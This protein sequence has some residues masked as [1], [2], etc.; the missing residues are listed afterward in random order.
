M[1]I[2]VA[3]LFLLLFLH[4]AAQVRGLVV[5]DSDGMEIAG[6]AVKAFGRDSLPLESR[7]TGADGR[8]ALSIS[9]DSVRLVEISFTGYEAAKAPGGTVDLGVV[10]LKPSKVVLDAVTVT[11][12]SRRQEAG[13]E[14]ILLTDSIRNSAGTAALMMDALP[15]FKVDWIS[16]SVSVGMDK[17]VPI[18]VNGRNVGLQYAKSLNPKR[19]KLIEVLRFPPGEFSDYPILINIVLF[20]SYVGWDAA[21]G[22]SGVA[23]TRNE[24]TNQE[25]ASADATF[26]TRTWSAY[27]SIS[28]KRGDTYESESYRR[29]VEGYA[30]EATAPIDVDKPNLRRRFSGN[31]FSAGADKRI[32]GRHTISL[33]TWLD[34]S[35]SRSRDAY[36]MASGAA[37]ASLDKYN[38]LNSVTGLFYSGAIGDRLLVYSNLQY[39][40]YDIDEH[41]DFTYGEESSPSRVKGRKDYAYFS[42]TGAY[43]LSGHWQ[44]SLSYSYTWRKYESHENGAEDAFTSR[45]GRNRAEAAVTFAPSNKFSLRAGGSMLNISTHA[46]GKEDSHTTWIPRAQA[47]YAPFRW[48]RMSGVYYN[49]TSYPNF[50]QLSTAS[51][52]V[53][54]H[55]RQTGNPALRSEVFHYLNLQATFLDFI[56]FNYLWR[57]S[58]DNIAD[59]YE[60]EEPGMVTKTY[61]NCDYLSQ[62]AGVSVDKN[63]ARGLNLNFVGS[64]QWYKRWS[65]GNR[66]SGRTWYG[67][68]TLAYA[69]GRTGLTVMGEYFL[70]HDLE[71]L[72]Q[73]R[74]YNQQEML[75]LGANYRLLKNRLSISFN[76][77]IPTSLLSKRTYTKINIQGFK[78]ETF[79]DDR[80]NSSMLQL[81]IRC[82]IGKGKVQKSSNDYNIDVEK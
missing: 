23:S 75:T 11:A 50:D 39:N 10:R 77:C 79:R 38:S 4:G 61:I 42:A 8:F 66:N 33:Q 69:I 67:D 37:Q 2:W 65:G 73:G 52:M 40:Y 57:K 35:R 31:S 62:Y 49:E 36:E 56:T 45:E 64:Y 17:D 44:A 53:S 28:Y 48:L 60:M 76:A 78:S 16:E 70:R 7:V 9:P 41:R 18:V 43:S 51:W 32:G 20:E 1:R 27:G 82:N 72:P 58:D 13:K 14:T 59:W 81:S 55:M 24:H 63:L 19:I 80:V 34:Q 5:D 6:A 21:A 54:A 25:S 68:L 30:P 71:P 47:Y 22:A 26:S 29:E 46:G 15:G 74:R 12:E 3:T